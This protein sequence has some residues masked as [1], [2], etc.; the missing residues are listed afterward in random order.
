M[1][2]PDFKETLD[3]DL[4]SGKLTGSKIEGR[5]EAMEIQR[6][7]DLSSLDL[8]N[9][10][11]PFTIA[12]AI[13]DLSYHRS[14]M[15]DELE[16]FGQKGAENVEAFKNNWLKIY[17]Q[18]GL[19][20]YKL[21]DPFETNLKDCQVTLGFEC[22]IKGHEGKGTDYISVNKDKLLTKIIA[23]RH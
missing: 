10:V 2:A 19:A 8:L 4:Q 5:V 16:A 7:N 3:F 12:D 17:H 6:E 23:I 14:H 9:A 20:A 21:E 1:K 15:A 13:C 11:V 22:I 18:Q